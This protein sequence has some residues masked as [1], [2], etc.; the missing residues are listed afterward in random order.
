MNKKII[1]L[2]ITFAACTG[3]LLAQTAEATD[4]E[5]F[6]QQRAAAYAEALGLDAR[7]TAKLAAVYLEADAEVAPLRDQ[8]AAIKAKAEA[9]VAPYDARVEGLLS[10]EQRVKLATMKAEGRFTPGDACCVEE[11]KAGCAGHGTA[12]GAA[13]GCCAGKAGAAHGEA[14]PAKRTPT[15]TLEPDPK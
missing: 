1:A 8:C 5:K 9:A 13:G 15:P 10:K 4:A 6:A 12:A 2:G 14:A 7:T 11:G 3:S